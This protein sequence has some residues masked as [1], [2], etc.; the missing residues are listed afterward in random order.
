M[1]NG[2]GWSARM[3]AERSGDARLARLFGTAGRATPAAAAEQLADMRRA[4]AMASWSELA[5]AAWAGKVR[6]V[7]HLLDGGADPNTID[8][9]GRSALFR[10]VSAG[11]GRMASLLIQRGAKPDVDGGVS[12]VHL[13]AEKGPVSVL[14]A[15]LAYPGQ[16]ERLDA[17]GQTPLMAA[18]RADNGEAVRLLLAHDADPNRADRDGLTPLHAAAQTGDAALAEHLIA[19]GARLD[20]E[21]D[22][23]RTPL[24][25]AARLGRLSV[26]KLLLKHSASAIAGASDGT[27]PLH[28]AAE[29]PEPEVLTALLDHDKG[30]NAASRT[31]TTPLLLAAARGRTDNVRVLIAAGADVDARNSVGDTP[32]ICAARG[33]HLESARLLLTAGANFRQ[34]NARHESARQLGVDRHDP[35]W[36]ALFASHGR[37]LDL[38]R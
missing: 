22:A 29:L 15:L 12:L 19:A 37:V 38:L 1:R 14:P 8:P 33:G 24:W 20:A 5:I 10:A 9:S 26:V 6:L 23:G 25:W 27:T 16:L 30:V 4:P 21:D 17:S 3:L 13:V 35:Q 2:A 36:D 7:E 31:G 34:R 32:L 11:H 28:V 18:A